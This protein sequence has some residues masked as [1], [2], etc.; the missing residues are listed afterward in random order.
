MPVPA[1]QR[2]EASSASTAG[3][4]AY[5]SSSRAR[6][7]S[8]DICEVDILAASSGTD[9]CRRRSRPSTSSE[10]AATASASELGTLP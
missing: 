1:N 10:T 2:A 7:V 6:V 3:R 4:G 9:G 8:K 5:P